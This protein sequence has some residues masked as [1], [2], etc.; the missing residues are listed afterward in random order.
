[1]EVWL[2]ENIV[3]IIAILTSVLAIVVSVIV[4]KRTLDKSEETAKKYGDVAGT[5]A[6][7]E[8]EEQKTA[9]ARAVALQ[10]LVND[11]GRARKISDFDTQILPHQGAIRLPML[12]FETAFLSG[13]SILLGEWLQA[14]G[15]ELLESVTTYLAAASSINSL[16]DV[17]LSYSTGAGHASTTNLMHQACEDIRKQAGELDQ[18]LDQLDRQLRA[19]LEKQP[20]N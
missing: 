3:G 5:K 19:E 6:A 9:K 13:E 16:I 11:V 1:M 10:A 8:Y 4:S 2:E 18:I 14:S 12:A 17:H 7:I 20:F 15:S